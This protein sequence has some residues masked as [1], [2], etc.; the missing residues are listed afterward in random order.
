MQ[1]GCLLWQ[2]TPCACE[3]IC[4][5]AHLSRQKKLDNR[6][7]HRTFTCVTQPTALDSRPLLF[8]FH[9]FVFSKPRAHFCFRRRTRRTCLSSLL[10]LLRRLLR[11][12]SFLTHDRPCPDRRSV[13]SEVVSAATRCGRALFRFLPEVVLSPFT[14]CKVPFSTSDGTATQTL[15]KETKPLEH[16]PGE[17]R[18]PRESCWRHVRLVRAS[19]AS[20]LRKSP[21]MLTSPAR[22]PS[23]EDGV[24]LILST[25]YPS[26]LS[27]TP[28]CR[29][30]LHQITPEGVPTHVWPSNDLHPR[31]FLVRES[32]AETLLRAR[33]SRRTELSC[34]LRTPVA[35]LLR[36][37]LSQSEFCRN[38]FLSCAA[39]SMIH[40]T[41]G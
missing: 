36:L 35:E 31:F 19:V 7:V 12:F 16:L 41:S 2:T 18:S 13:L 6:A 29:T 23:G 17:A 11:V 4:N 3:L 21:W 10:F 24:P 40:G 32:C 39:C 38:L 33:A 28:S 27:P 30:V 8:G 25:S 26:H 1:R 34:R 37:S 22:S 15:G 14:I 9:L 5:E 20:C